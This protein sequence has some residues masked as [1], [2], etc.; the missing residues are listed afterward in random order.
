M[1]LYTCCFTLC[2]ITRRKPTCVFTDFQ[3]AGFA[4]IDIH[5]A[6]LNCGDSEFRASSN[7]L[8]SLTCLK[9]VGVVFFKENMRIMIYCPVNHG[10]FSFRRNGNV[11]PLSCFVGSVMPRHLAVFVQSAL[12]TMR[13]SDSISTTDSSLTLFQCLI[14]NVLT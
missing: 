10:T 13:K 1:L 3:L 14:L 12:I 7:F 5:E 4:L 9:R 8:M 11:L 6:A 2:N